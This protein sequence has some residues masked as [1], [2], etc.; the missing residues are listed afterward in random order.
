MKK[1]YQYYT[2]ENIENGNNDF[3]KKAL[4]LFFYKS[5]F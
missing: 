2:P 3:M 5:H 1:N 4:A